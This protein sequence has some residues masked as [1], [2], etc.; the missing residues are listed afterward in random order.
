MSQNKTISEC[1]EQ[2][3]ANNND[4]IP[5]VD[6]NETQIDRQNK[7]ITV[8]NLLQNVS[9]GREKLTSDRVYYIDANNGDDDNDGELEASAFKTLNKAFELIKTTIDAAGFKIT[10]EASPGE[11]RNA[12][13]TIDKGQGNI[14]G[15]HYH[16]PPVVGYSHYHDV[17]L[18]IKGT[19]E[20]PTDT[21]IYGLELSHEF[22]VKISNL[23]LK[24]SSDGFNYAALKVSRSGTAILSAIALDSISPDEYSIGLEATEG[25]VIVLTN[26]LLVQGS[27]NVLFN[28]E[29]AGSIVTKNVFLPV[30]DPQPDFG[31]GSSFPEAI[32]EAN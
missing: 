7:K 4:I 1:I 23:T 2:S 27:F 5:L 30:F 31:Q 17:P 29:S 11:Y 12:E 6:L 9:G 26:F 32:P 10:I 28:T 3:I 8:E 20:N 25:G 19:G 13:N 21:V 15:G 24:A 22:S 18:T 14:V 16:I